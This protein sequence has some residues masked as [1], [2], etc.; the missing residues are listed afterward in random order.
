M[1]T[2]ISSTQENSTV[3]LSFTSGIYDKIDISGVTT[4][5]G[6]SNSIMAILE[7]DEFIG[8]SSQS[9]IITDPDIENSTTSYFEGKGLTII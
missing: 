8:I 3:L 1:N 7:S 2:I 4:I 9:L 6:T 5:T